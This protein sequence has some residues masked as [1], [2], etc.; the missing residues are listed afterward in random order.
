MYSQAFEKYNTICRSFF[1]ICL[2]YENADTFP[3][4][5]CT[6]EKAII[7]ASM[8]VGGIHYCFIKGFDDTVFA[9]NPEPGI[10]N[11]V[12]PVASSFDDFLRLTFTL[13]GTQ[14]IDQIPLLD[15]ERFNAILKNHIVDLSPDAA[16]E[17]DD[18][19]D[20]FNLVTLDD[21]YGYV[22]GLV[23]SFDYKKIC[24]SE[25]YYDVLGIE[26][27]DGD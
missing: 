3:N 7:F 23:N 8:G 6:P 20:T 19:R 27:A 2:R 21:P 15:K 4:Y 24:Y 26:K 17:I 12:F 1:S 25:E 18:L 16:R 9:V 13:R 11:H 22:M 10:D 5:F 14:L